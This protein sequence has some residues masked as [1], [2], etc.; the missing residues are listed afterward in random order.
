MEEK[1]GAQK[2]LLTHSCTAALEMSAILC[3]VGPGDKV[4]LPSFTFVSTANAFYLRGAKLVFVD[5]PQMDWLWH[6]WALIAAA[7]LSQILQ[8]KNHD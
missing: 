5:V 2:I 1:F 3:D 7:N 4:I 6:G 8:G